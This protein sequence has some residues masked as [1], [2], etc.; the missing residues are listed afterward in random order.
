MQTNI[1]FQKYYKR[2]I[3]SILQI[4][5][6]II[7]SFYISQMVFAWPIPHSGQT[8]CYDNEKEIP[9]PKPGED[10][11]GQDGNYII[12]PPSYTKLDANGNPLP[13]S[14]A[15][16]VMIKDNVTG[17]IWEVKT[18][19]DSVHDKYNRYSWQDA[20][21]VFIS[22]LNNKNFGG[23][24]D[25]RLPNIF[26][27]T[28]ITN[29]S[30]IVPAI[31]EQYFK[32]YMSDFYWSST[33]NANYTGNAWGVHFHYG[34]D[35]NNSKSSAY[36]VRA[37]RS[38]QSRL[39]GH[40][41]IN[42]DGTITDTFT[43]L[44][45]QVEISEKKYWKDGLK[46]CDDLIFADYDDWRLPSRD[47]LRSIVD[48]NKYYPAI[49]EDVFSGVMSDF[50]WSSTTHADYTGRAWGVDFRN[51]DGHGY[52]KSSA[53]YVRAVRSGQ[54]RS[55]GN[56][57]IWSP[58][59]AAFLINGTK[60]QITWDS[61]DIQ[62]PIKI[63][64]SRQGGKPDT[65]ETIISETD[66]DGY[67]EWKI[68][69]QPSV[70]C[71]LKIE[72]I[73][74][75]DKGTQQSLFTIKNPDIIVN[76]NI[77]SQFTISG[78]KS[79]TGIGSS[80]IVGNSEPGIYTITYN[81][82]SCWETP[83]SESQSLT[84]WDSIIFSG[85]YGT[86]SA[87]PIQNIRACKEIK[88]WTANNQITVQ[89]Q[90][91]EQCLKGYSYIWDNQENT[92]P[93]NI[94]SSTN[95][96][97]ISPKLA[98]GN[99]HWFHIKSI[100]IHGYESETIH[101]GP[102]FIDTS[103][104]PPAPE[105]LKIKLIAN[106]NI[107]LE[108][109]PVPDTSISYLIYR[110]QV[111]NG[112]F[113]PVNSEPVDYY[114]VILN[115]FTD[116][117]IKPGL[118]Y[119]YKIKSYRDDVESQLFSNTISV[120]SLN[121]EAAFDIF[122]INQTHKIVPTGG[123]VQFD[124]SLSKSASFQ[125]Y[126]DIWCENLP[127]NV[128]YELSVNHQPGDIRLEKIDELPATLSLSLKAR[129]TA[130]PDD[131]C[132]DLI[133]LNNKSVNFEQKSWHMY[134]TIVSR[135]TGGMFVDV[136][137]PHIHKN[138]NV[139][140]FGCIYPPLENES[141]ILEAWKNKEKYS[142]TQLYTVN[143]G[144]FEKNQ[145]INGFEPGLY[146]IKAE[147][148]GNNSVLVSAQS[149]NL[150]IEKVLPKIL[151]Y[152]KENEIPK[153][154]QEFEIT[155]Q[156]EPSIENVPIK[157]MVIN[158]DQTKHHVNDL[159]TDNF[160]QFYLSDLFFKEK[161]KYSFIAYYL[162]NETSIGC[163]SQTYDVMVGNNGYAI[164]IGGGQADF[165]NTYWN[166]T[167]ELIK[168]AYLSFKSMGFSD[169][170]IYL[171]INSK[172][173][174]I[175]G[176]EIPDHV[177]NDDTPSVREFLNV[178]KNQFRDFL[179][180]DETLY[181]FMQGHGTDLGSFKVLGSDEYISSSQLNDALTDIQDATQCK[182]V[183]ILEFCYSGA[184]I[185]DLTYQ[186]RIILTSAGNEPYRTDD[187][188]S[189][190]FSKYL[191]SRLCTGDSIQKSFSYSKYELTNKRYPSPLL[192]DNGD[193]ISNDNDGQLALKIYPKSNL[194]WYQPE[195]SKIELNP[196]LDGINKLSVKVTVESISEN[197]E[198][199]WAQVI[200]PYVNITNGTGT[201]HFPETILHNDQ[202]NVYIGD[203]KDFTYDGLYTVIFYSQNKSK[204]TS[205]SEQRFVRAMNI[206]RRT[207][208]NFDEK[209]DLKD[210]IIVVKALT[211]CYV[212]DNIELADAIWLIQ[213]LG[214]NK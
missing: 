184:F 87:I 150:I 65:F 121:D 118:T 89:W 54:S 24:S 34:N 207:D 203:I 49:Y 200:P 136:I 29:L 186:N 63:Y 109:L 57:I 127:D 21:D 31:N 58:Q 171:M 4:I 124:I 140:I 84:Y 164:I 48:Y 42:N 167:K 47:E 6:M 135:S 148:S 172:M 16:W 175:N 22:E 12:N 68:S 107:Q 202:G 61:A 79:Y 74:S 110:S 152:S 117:D 52:S 190:S 1:I 99:N 174:D 67:Y 149:Q 83:V 145:W 101:L 26:E 82:I 104:A 56:L 197:I 96:Q 178:I 177:V 114:D 185:K 25:W 137:P 100:N 156:I 53:Y 144:C 105:G 211:D 111:E 9:C 162:G 71:A 39:F 43:G 70:N 192:D 23:N 158:P 88:T 19:D 30:K 14:S 143:G 213:F 206:G 195:I 173:I 5:S 123:K 129:S 205:K 94:I 133:C 45:W 73:I 75:H 59:Q 194:D 106:D 95:P 199:V 62:E 146:S 189:I 60:T 122:F 55:F 72:P 139:N 98:N 116:T 125:G 51:G 119:F 187:S 3:L 153:H 198:K 81:T 180:A 77:D 151:L 33:T 169:E 183:V 115:G 113:Y 78:P 176:D 126:L 97:T 160:G 161:G 91:I 28:S 90:P 179:G 36:Y 86:T 35:F 32:N 13:D 170:M 103:L 38:G 66:N 44:M 112:I 27:L 50:Y 64:L 201:I 15:T 17:L 181:L 163:E 138:E 208:Y 46:Y 108:W 166:V 102:F 128:E 11:Y 204:E 93:D 85:N 214:L 154:D 142:S 159:F 80:F 92:E 8:K 134:L 155:G 210:L 37:V 193:G 2:K 182:I 20:Q 165:Y 10:F 120:I 41:V 130:N 69:G 76:S 7:L 40:L 196:V 209:T 191:F 157:L 168:N 188:G 147:W 18:D 212:I 131:Y 132:F 141:I